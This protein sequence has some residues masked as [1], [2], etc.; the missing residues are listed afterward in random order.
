[1]NINHPYTQGRENFQPTQMNVM[2]MSCS[3]LGTF[4][5]SRINAATS[6]L[7]P[8]C[9]YCWYT[10]TTTPTHMYNKTPTKAFTSTSYVSKHQCQ[11]NMCNWMN[12]LVVFSCV[13]QRF[14]DT[15]KCQKNTIVYIS[16]WSKIHKHTRLHAHTTHY[17]HVW[18][19]KQKLTLGKYRE[20][21]RELK[22]CEKREQNR[23]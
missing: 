1:M 10:K 21:E 20:S 19:N 6:S 7:I 14:S 17:T 23:T 3:V 13:A 22:W 5:L 15:N 2:Y 8:N 18:A 9:W 4:F 12:F 16:I 11:A